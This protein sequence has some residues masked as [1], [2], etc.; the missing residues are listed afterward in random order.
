VVD[1]LLSDEKLAQLLALRA[2]YPELDYKRTI[3]LSTT[4]GR[5]ELAKD[6]AAMQVRAGYIIVGVA[7]DGT[8]TATLTKPMRV[9]LTKRMASRDCF[10]TCRSRWNCGPAWR[11]IRDTGWC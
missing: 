5:V 7:D 2:E 6:V 3:D 10:A 8:P 9:P 11:S 1:G 4:Q